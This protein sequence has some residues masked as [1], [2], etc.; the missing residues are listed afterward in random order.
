MLLKT[1]TYQDKTSGWTLQNLELDRFNLLVGASGVGKTRILQAI[2]EIRATA[3]LRNQETRGLVGTGSDVAIRFAIKFEHEGQTYAWE[4][5][6]EPRNSDPSAEPSQHYLTPVRTIVTRERLT[7]SD[8]GVLIDRDSE[9]FLFLG[10]ELPLLRRSETALALLDEPRIQQVRRALIYQLLD[11]RR[12]DI[13][14]RYSEASLQAALNKLESLEQ[15]RA[16][17]LS[18]VETKAFLLQERFPAQFERIKE[19]FIEIFPSV[20]DVSVTKTSF[21]SLPSSADVL[22]HLDFELKER[23]VPARFR[24]ED[25]SSGM[26]RTLTH[27]IEL[28]LAPVGAVVLIDEFENSLGVNCM[29]PLTEFIQSRASELQFIITSHHPYI[30]NKIPK[31]HWKVVR[32]KGSVV[33]VTP[34]SEIKALQGAS[35]QDDFTRLLNSPEFEEGLA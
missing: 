6:S 25:L 12:T 31:S 28:W 24:S 22:I 10:H 18:R 3:Y 5:E 26:H 7:G 32:R 8:S 29:G 1:L 13:V 20:E 2:R 30:I 34:A 11:D 19:L 4:F 21:G 17:T 14:E 27:L 16:L 15:L 23:G 9:R 35:A 33:T